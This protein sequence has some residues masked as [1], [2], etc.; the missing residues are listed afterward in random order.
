[1]T[2]SKHAITLALVTAAL[3][4]AAPATAAVPSGQP[5]A[6]AAQPVEEDPTAYVTLGVGLPTLVHAEAGYY[7]T[8]STSIDVIGALI[9][10]NLMGGVGATQWFS[11]QS[12]TFDHDLGIG[13]HGYLNLIDEPFEF[14]SGSERLGLTFDAMLAYAFT[15]EAGF[16]VRAQL[17]ALIYDDAGVQVSPNFLAMAGWRF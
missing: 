17:G 10:F 2:D 6:G 13:V 4:V 5:Q 8:P 9:V 11:L 15:L 14:E 16:T 12:G 7:I 1:M 3:T